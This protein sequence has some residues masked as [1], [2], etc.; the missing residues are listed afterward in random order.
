MVLICMSKNSFWGGGG[1]NYSIKYH[2]IHTLSHFYKV[3]K[4]VNSSILYL[5]H[6][7]KIFLGD[8][9][10][11]QISLRDRLSGDRPLGADLWGTDLFGGQTSMLRLVWGAYL[12]LNFESSAMRELRCCLLSSLLPLIW[13]TVVLTYSVP[14]TILYIS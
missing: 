13:V 7:S 1:D 12:M 2:V 4:N 3:Y 14:C 11:G 9:L 8:R 5:F 6:N 10:L